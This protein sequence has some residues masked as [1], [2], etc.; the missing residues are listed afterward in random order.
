MNK[1]VLFISFAG[2]FFFW[3]IKFSTDLQRRKQ[4]IN[5]DKSDGIPRGREWGKGRIK[6]IAHSRFTGRALS[7]GC[8]RNLNGPSPFLACLPLVPTLQDNSKSTKSGFLMLMLK[9]STQ[10]KHTSQKPAFLKHTF[11]THTEEKQLHINSFYLNPSLKKKK[12]KHFNGYCLVT[13]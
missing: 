11:E 2:L 9:P 1:K 6:V 12:K 8:R 4:S 7:R 13:S 3:F 10:L 5:V